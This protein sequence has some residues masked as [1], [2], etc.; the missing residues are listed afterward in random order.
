MANGTN[1]TALSQFLQYY[2]CLG[3]THKAVIFILRIED[4]HLVGTIVVYNMDL[5]GSALN[6]CSLETICPY[7][8]CRHVAVR[9]C[10]VGS[11]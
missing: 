10:T 7:P 1:S 6:H 4:K 2:F 5:H 8:K 9:V 3:L 11:C